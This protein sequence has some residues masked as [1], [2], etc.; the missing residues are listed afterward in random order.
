MSRRKPTPQDWFVP[1]RSGLRLTPLLSTTAMLLL[2][3]APGAVV[4]EQS[5]NV[6]VAQDTQ[7]ADDDLLGDI[8][9]LQR[10]IDATTE[11]DQAKRASRTR[12]TD[13]LKRADELVQAGDLAGAEDQLTQA[14]EA[15]L[16]DDTLTRNRVTL[17]RATVKIRRGDLAGATKLLDTVSRTGTLS[18]AEKTRIDTLK[19]RIASAT[20]DAQRR[21]AIAE[22][23][24]L[25]DDAAIQRARDEVTRDPGNVGARFVLVDLLRQARQFD[26]AQR[27]AETLLADTA[28]DPGDHQ[29]ALVALGRIAADRGDFAAAGQRLDELKASADTPQK[30][31]RIA[32][33]EARI[34][35][36]KEQAQS[37]ALAA[38]RQTALD[39]ITGLAGQ[40]AIQRARDEVA[41]D[42]GN[43]DARLLLGD[44]LRRAG[45]YEEAGQVAESLAAA[46]ETEDE[47]AVRQ[48]AL[49]LLG[50]T[51]AD[52]GDFAAADAAVA[53]LRA[54]AET[55]QKGERIADLE[56][57]IARQKER[58]AAQA[59]EAARRAATTEIANLPG[60]EQIERARAEVARDPGNTGAR[61]LLGDLLRAAKQ[62][63]EATQIADAIIAEPTSADDPD[64][65][66]RALVLLGRTEADAGD[67]AAARAAAE[68][69]RATAETAQ[70]AARVTDLE[71]RIA[72]QEQRAKLAGISALP[73]A[74]AIA[75]ARA[76]VAANPDNL[77]AQL[78]LGDLLMRAGQIEEAA[79]IAAT[80]AASPA[81]GA[82]PDLGQRALVLLGRTAADDGDFAAARTTLE[83]LRAT[84]E[85]PQKAARLDDLSARIARQEQRARLAE[86]S[87]LPSREAIAHAR[88]EVA[89][90]PGNAGAQLLLGDL[91]RRAGQFE[92]AR[93]IAEALTAADDPDLAQRALVLL[94][95][96]AADDGSF[97]AARAVADRLRAT[98]ETPQKATRVADLEA[99]IA[100]QE[101]RA[102]LA[103]IAGMPASQAIAAARAEVAADPANF[104]A[105]L[106]LGDLLRR[107]GKVEEA[108]QIGEAIAA[109][110]EATDDAD[111]QQRAL[112]LLGRVAIDRGNLPAARD[113]LKRLG[114]T[115]D[116]PQKALRVQDLQDRITKAAAKAA[117][118]ARKAAE[119]AENERIDAELAAINALPLAEA[120]ERSRAFYAANPGNERIA[121]AHA[122]LLTRAW[123]W[124]E[125]ETVYLSMLGPLDGVSDAVLVEN[126]GAVLGLVDLYSRTNRLAQANEWLARLERA[127][128]ADQAPERAAT[129]R[130][131][132]DDDLQPDQFSGSLTMSVGYN[133]NV[134]AP[135]DD[136]FD[137]NQTEQLL[138]DEGSSFVEADLRFR[139]DHIVSPNGD[140]LR[141]QARLQGRPY[142]EFEGVDRASYD[143]NGGYVHYVPDTR[144]QIQALAGYK[145]RYI[146]YDSYRRTLYGLLNANTDVNPDLS[147]AGTAK[148][149]ANDDS[150][151]DLD[152]WAGE[153]DGRVAY[154]L[155][156]QTVVGLRLNARYEDAQTAEDSR[157]IYGATFTI[158][159]DFAIG[160][161]D[162]FYAL[163]SYNPYFTQ[164]GG[165]LTSGVDAGVTREDFTQKVAFAIGRQ[166][167]DIWRVELNG[168]YVI[169]SSNVEGEDDNGAEIRFS[170]TRL[171]S[172]GSDFDD[173]N[174]PR[175][176]RP[177]AISFR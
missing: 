100:R 37:Q 26:D 137:D 162:N 72:R 98:P 97:A 152:G 66:Q 160:G 61:L 95:R 172:G 140:R 1:A 58:A 119:R 135:T 11:A 30:A 59:L 138:P 5:N 45:Q 74:E 147:I 7:G 42:P 161:W 35:R 49:V 24:T 90:D 70:K 116:T 23:S 104:A 28:K 167:S 76:E 101:Q 56:A 64:L 165:P 84:P 46:P 141:L 18:D 105:R 99:A 118:D 173:D 93:Q 168:N 33:L 63:P 51:A 39:A 16:A 121:N 150:E 29:R 27:A 55:P 50:R 71:S 148:V 114:D 36:E 14:D 149:E 94:G 107:A 25:A 6:Q 109:S 106:L 85:T 112:M 170:V 9:A 123:E 136:F 153:L 125:A 171:F 65:T 54:T 131:R 132:I 110:P 111:L 68:R 157:G 52:D 17:A 158:R 134:S 126:S 164:Y 19:A 89:R 120:V 155:G 22:I 53:R 145:N 12:V 43:F 48:R 44:L 87:T 8:E 133:S 78:L 81:A 115:A 124:Q 151:S 174:Q 57:R 103:E 102:R 80:V 86:I 40:E 3:L 169:R 82:N 62:Y 32:D 15:A 88:E 10:Q 21:A 144:T 20:T 143:I 2:L 177:G 154:D 128:P 113:V 77:D 163:A 96:T 4:A 34:A 156:P 175:D 139:Y 41:R 73:A 122:R 75:Q 176:V 142:L 83:R 67:F 129:L 92:E 146:D 91:L 130:E 69:L 166:V 38:T 159:Q 47:P 127:Y 108:T 13:L 79:Q 60:P 31:T 117:D